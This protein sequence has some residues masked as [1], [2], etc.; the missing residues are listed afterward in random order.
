MVTPV[1]RTS[2]TDVAFKTS[3]GRAEVV[4]RAHR[5]TPLERALLIVADGRQEFAG[6]LAALGRAAGGGDIEAAA[7]LSR[8]IELGLLDI[9][10]PAPVASAGRKSLALARL[11]LIESVE[12]AL[13]GQTDALKPLLRD[14]TDEAGVRRALLACEKALLDAGAAR[15]A[16]LIRARC[17]ELLP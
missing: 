10:R 16:S 4:R 2:A 13:R 14:A 7:A 17:L 12:R 3:S 8:L 15:Q 9:E 5:L 1:H 11:Y 6:L